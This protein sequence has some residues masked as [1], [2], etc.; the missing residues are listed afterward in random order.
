SWFFF[1]EEIG[2]FYSGRE[3]MPL[4]QR[5]AQLFQMRR[6]AKIVFDTAAVGLN[7]CRYNVHVR[8]SGID[9]SVGQPWLFGKTDPFH[10][11]GRDG[12]HLLIG[13]IVSCQ[14]L[15]ASRSRACCCSTFCSLYFSEA[16]TLFAALTIASI[17]L[18]FHGRLNLFPG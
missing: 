10:K 15:W 13:E 8:V 3:V 12:C 9:M 7:V 1:F 14:K 18:R 5:E 6:A 4:L 17:F 16:R 2:H 11:P